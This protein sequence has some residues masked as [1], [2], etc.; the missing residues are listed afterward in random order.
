[1]SAAAGAGNLPE[2]LSPR[3]W[4]ER[5]IQRTRIPDASFDP[6]GSLTSHYTQMWAQYKTAVG[7]AIRSVT[8]LFMVSALAQLVAWLESYFGIGARWIP[9]LMSAAAFL[10]SLW[11]L[12]KCLWQLGAAE[13]YAREWKQLEII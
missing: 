6:G 5:Q 8:S 10:L 3:A 2:W 9:M 7:L 11:L 1:M 13:A 4:T 12:L